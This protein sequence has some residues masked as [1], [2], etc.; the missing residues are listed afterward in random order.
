MKKFYQQV[1]F[2]EMPDE[3][4]AN[5]IEMEVPDTVENEAVFK[6]ID[7]AQEAVEPDDDMDRLSQAEAIYTVAME[8]VGGSWKWLEVSGVLEIE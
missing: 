6:A 1:Y 7:K 5:I 4:E 3:Y 8:A 2:P